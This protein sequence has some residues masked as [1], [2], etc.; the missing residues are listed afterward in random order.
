MQKG[1]KIE[2]HN[3]IKVFMKN[4]NIAMISLIC[5]FNEK[6]KKKKKKPTLRF[7]Q[8]VQK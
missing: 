3:K 7:V 6:Q 5:V 1:F 2:N 4:N 8:K